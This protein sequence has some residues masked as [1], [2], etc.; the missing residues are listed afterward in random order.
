M[1]KIIK[2][3]EKRIASFGSGLF[4]TTSRLNVSRKKAKKPHK[5]PKKA[6]KTKPK[7]AKVVRTNKRPSPKAETEYF[8]I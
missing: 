7:V 2:G 5:K 3:L 8:I 1:R 6:K 4:D